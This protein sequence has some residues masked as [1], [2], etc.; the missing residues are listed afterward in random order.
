MSTTQLLRHQA[1]EAK[2]DR[3]F[4]EARKDGIS[5][6]DLLANMVSA[7]QRAQFRARVKAAQERPLPTKNDPEMQ[8]WDRINRLIHEDRVSKRTK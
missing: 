6:Q 3:L 4:A 2:L 1:L 7:Y 5:E 8:E